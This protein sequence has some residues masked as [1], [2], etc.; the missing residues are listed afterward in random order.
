MRYIEL[1]LD[2][3]K[4][5]CGYRRFFVVHEGKLK[6]RLFYP[7]ECTSVEVPHAELRKA[8]DITPANRRE[9][10]KVAAVIRDNFKMRKRLHMAVAGRDA[11]AVMNDLKG[12]AA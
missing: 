5:G 2:T 3:A 7:S 4:T 12:I 6:T 8:K 11:K 1:Y 10:A 9:A